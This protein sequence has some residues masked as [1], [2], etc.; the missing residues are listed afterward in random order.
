MT[1][2]TGAAG[3]MSNCVEATVGFFGYNRFDSGKI[4]VS[5]DFTANAQE[6]IVGKDPALNS[7]DLTTFK[8]VLYVDFLQMS[9]GSGGPIALY[10]GSG[11]T[12]IA[13]LAGV[14]VGGGNNGMWDFRGDPLVCLTADNTQSL[15]ISSA[16][17]M[18]TGFVKCHWGTVSK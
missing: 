4:G 3:D 6:R 7:N 12:L 13:A 1:L 18:N 2:T 8:Q 9:C 14:S 16:D 5:W 17:A 11:G 10:D 15:C